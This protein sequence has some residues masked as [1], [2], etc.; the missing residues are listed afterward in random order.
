M[1][2]SFLQHASLLLGNAEGAGLENTFGC[3]SGTSMSASA[4]SATTTTATTTTTTTTT[5]AAATASGSRSDG[6]ISISKHPFEDA[7]SVCGPRS[8]EGADLLEFVAWGE[9]KFQ[10]ERVRCVFEEVVPSGRCSVYYATNVTVTERAVGTL[11]AASG[12][13][14][15]FSSSLL[16]CPPAYGGSRSEQEEVGC[17]VYLES[18]DP[19]SRST[20][21]RY[22]PFGTY[23]YQPNIFAEEAAE[24]GAEGPAEPVC[25]PRTPADQV[26]PS[27]SSG[28]SGGLGG[29]RGG[30]PRHSYLHASHLALIQFVESEIIG[31]VDE[32]PS[33]PSAK[34]QRLQHLL[35]ELAF[36]KVCTGPD[37]K[38]NPLFLA[39]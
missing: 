31:G 39:E 37:G 36:E 20:T 15:I 38:R 21:A 27:G 1:S 2:P 29:S 6:G 16:V 8:S 9:Y 14:E 33:V 5:S 13:Q 22:G 35:K 7:M 11:H 34:R 26:M 23:N 4:S 3:S 10:K 25:A 18:I 30:A 12:R 32:V 17:A 24:G 19:D 28:S